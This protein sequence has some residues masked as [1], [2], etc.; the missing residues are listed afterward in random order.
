MKSP[1]TTILSKLN[2]IC[3][4]LLVFVPA[5]LVSIFLSPAKLA[6]LSAYTL[7]LAVLARISFTQLRKLIIPF[8]LM[9]AVTLAMHLLFTRN[10]S[11]DTTAFGFFAVNTHAL[12][13][14][15]L[16]CWRIALFFL[17]GLAFVRSVAKEEFAEVVWR[18]LLPLRFLRVPVND[19]AM[20]LTIAIRFI[21]ETIAEYR[22]IELL[23]K[24]R[25]AKI[26][27]NWVNRVRRSAPIIIPAV[28]SAL[29]R[30][31]T[32]ADALVVRHW[33][34]VPKRTFY[35]RLKFRFVDF[36]GMTLLAALLV[37]TLVRPA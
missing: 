26:G 31:D 30:I 16:Y 22:R 9:S 24:S 12:N 15:L 3:R 29:R 28:A 36:I 2:P 6:I 4:L 27:G 8:L 34:E 23:Q 1:D 37:S 13:T 35:R 17:L 20:A 33:G 7:V 21:P 32:T 5:I 10:S 19:L 25:G 18:L 11:T 14:G